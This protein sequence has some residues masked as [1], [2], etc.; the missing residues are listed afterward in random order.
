MQDGMQAPSLKCSDLLAVLS[1]GGCAEKC[2]GAD[3]DFVVQFLSQGLAP[4]ETTACVHATP[5]PA[6]AYTPAPSPDV[7]ESYAMP[8]DWS[9]LKSMCHVCSKSCNQMYGQCDCAP[10][11]TIPAEQAAATL[12]FGGAVGMAVLFLITNLTA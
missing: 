12:F 4:G 5:A 11:L 9:K 10:D 7:Q 1:A 6:P 8:F 3:R 2:S